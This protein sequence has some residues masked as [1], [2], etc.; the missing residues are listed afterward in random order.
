MNEEVL[1]FSDRQAFRDWLEANGPDSGGVW[2][3]FGKKGGPA[4][5]SANDA[6]E[7][8]LCYGWIDGQMESLDPTRYRKYFAR[9][10]AGSRWSAKNKQLV[11]TLIEKGIVTPHGHAAIEQAK[12]NGQWDAAK[13]RPVIDDD[14]LEAFREPVAPF[15]PAYTNLLA[16]S[17]SVQKNYTGFYLD[18]KSDK[19]RAARLEKIVDR[20]NQNLKPM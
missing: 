8:A 19:T 1:V 20:L 16:M 5:L 17:P 7:E 18:A 12:Q 6:L 10:T 15:E 14:Q 2:L 13:A 11:L 9:R 3:L 4:T